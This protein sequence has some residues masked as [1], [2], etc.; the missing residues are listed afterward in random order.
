MCWLFIGLD[1]TTFADLLATLPVMT[2]PV[3]LVP[4]LPTIPEAVEDDV[5]VAA[6]ATSPPGVSLLGLILADKRDKGDT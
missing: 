1:C 4:M 5:V 6:T 3:D 2:P